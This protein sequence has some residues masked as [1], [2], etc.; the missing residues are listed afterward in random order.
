MCLRKAHYAAEQLTQRAGM[1][2]RF[3]RP[4]FK[5]FTVTVPG[6]HPEAVLPGMLQAGFHAGL[7]LGRWY[8]GLRDAISLA[9]TEK[10]TK[11]EIDRLLEAYASEIKGRR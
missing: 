1:R 3:N 6:Q 11:A 2:L 8:P 5:E 9:V 10:R 4:F 7:H